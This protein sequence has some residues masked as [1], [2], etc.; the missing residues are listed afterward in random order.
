MKSQIRPAIGLFIIAAVIVIAVW[1]IDIKERKKILKSVTIA[2]FLVAPAVYPVIF[3]FL[4]PKGSQPKFYPQWLLV[5]LDKLEKNQLT[6]SQFSLTQLLA[7]T[8][9]VAFVLGIFKSI[10]TFDDPLTA[11]LATFVTVAAGGAVLIA[12]SKEL[13]MIAAIFLMY[14]IIAVLLGI[15]VVMIYWFRLYFG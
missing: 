2:T 1:I 3:I 10:S 12:R 7:S 9:I 13:A 15:I 6:E 14:I 5:F 11:L 4:T 8:A